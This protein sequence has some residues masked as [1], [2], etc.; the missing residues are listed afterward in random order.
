[1]HRRVLAGYAS[2]A[3]ANLDL[4]AAEKSETSETS[5]GTT[6]T[7]RAD[8]DDESAQLAAAWQWVLGATAGGGADEMAALSSGVLGASLHGLG[9][10]PVIS[11]S[12]LSV[13][14][15]AARG[16]LLCSFGW[17]VQSEPTARE[18][19]IAALEADGEYERAA[20]MALFQSDAHPAYD[21]LQR[22][23]L[24]LEAGS[25]AAATAHTTARASELRMMSMVLAV[26]SPD[27]ALLWSTVS[28]AASSIASPR[29]KLL[30]A[31]LCSPMGTEDDAGGASKGPSSSTS[32]TSSSLP[33]HAT[34]PADKPQRML[35]AVLLDS[36]SG[37]QQLTL[38]RPG[39]WRR[40]FE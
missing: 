19:A 23:V 28:A 10:E 9:S 18:E 30:L 29:L 14:A 34:S 24:C 12:G 38:N 7:R 8:G 11:Q 33:A 3:R 16:R 6:R 39:E 21:G 32:S 31:V 4:L 25:Q 40:A 35:H 37:A 26:Y 22:S 15:S 20:L 5:A 27:A 13:F 36:L 17:R 2:D 1:M